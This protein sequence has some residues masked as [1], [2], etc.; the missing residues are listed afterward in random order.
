ME[1]GVSRILIVDDYEDWRRW[2]SS[3]LHTEPRFTVVDEAG[4]GL[5]A[6]QKAQALQ[7]D[8]VILDIG[9]PLQSGIEAGRRITQLAPKAKI[10]IASENRSWDIVLASLKMGALGYLLK[11]DAGMELLPA[12]DA[13]LRGERFVSS[14]LNTDAP[15]NLASPSRPKASRNLSVVSH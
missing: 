1:Q 7:P 4:N 5:E 12:I 8:L 6:V 9:L 2:L 11:C 15:N 3:T 13:V 10:L 14:S